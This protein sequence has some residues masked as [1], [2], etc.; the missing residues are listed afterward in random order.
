MARQGDAEN[1]APLEVAAPPI[2]IQEKIH[3]RALIENLRRASA[4]RM[5]E[6]APQFDFFHDFN[7]L[8]AD[9][10]ARTEFYQHDQNWQNRIILGDSLLVMG[11]LAEREAL[12]GKVQCIYFDPPYGIKFNSN[13]QPSTKSRDVKDGK[14]DSVSREPEVIRAFRDTWKDGVHSYLSYLRDRL[15][16]ARDL[17]LGDGERVCPNPGD[18]NVL[19]RAIN[20]GRDIWEGKFF[21]R[22]N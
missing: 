5:T 12:R 13:W 3:P 7:G 1:R 17:L 4:A 15:T 9:R 8:E 10:E 11:S 22:T 21:L 20:F 14:E 6:N 2:Y 18:E 16:V 19:S